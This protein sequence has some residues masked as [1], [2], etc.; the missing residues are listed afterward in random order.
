[1]FVNLGKTKEMVLNTTIQWARRSSPPLTY[2]QETVEYVDA[3][4]HLGVVFSSLRR[5][6]KMTFVEAHAALGR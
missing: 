2:V 1:M 6:A 4:I 3:Y 5:A